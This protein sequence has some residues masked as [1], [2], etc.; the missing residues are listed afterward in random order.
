MT[1]HTVNVAIQVLPSGGKSFAYSVVD[2]AIETIAA[3]GL[4]YRVCPFETV[5]E[6]SYEQVI[7]LMREI[8]DVCFEAGAEDILINM[9]WQIGH[10]KDISISDKMGKYEK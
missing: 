5:V 4:I 9:K 2:R 3:S 7:Q 8:R 10:N 1:D 6:G